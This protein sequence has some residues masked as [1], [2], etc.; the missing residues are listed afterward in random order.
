MNPTAAVTTTTSTYYPHH[1]GEVPTYV[2]V[3]VLAIIALLLIR[4]LIGLAILCIIA[5]VGIALYHH[6]VLDQW[7]KIGDKKVHQIQTQIQTKNH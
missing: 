5:A 2:I 7:L 3:A 4:K 6:G 1:F